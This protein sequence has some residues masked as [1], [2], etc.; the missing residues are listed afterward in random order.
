MKQKGIKKIQGKMFRYIMPLNKDMR[1]IVKDAG[2]DF[3]YP[4][5]KDLEWKEF[6]SKGKYKKLK[7]MP[8]FALDVINLNYKN[9]H[10]H[11]K[12]ADLREF[13]G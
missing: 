3:N 6:V 9:V 4:K 13:F 8:K 10:A 7:E 11:K 1:K 2:W 5:D 12:G